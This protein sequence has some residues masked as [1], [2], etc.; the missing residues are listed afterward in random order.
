[1]SKKITTESFIAEAK[2]IYGDKYD[3]SKVNYINAK[4]K[5]CIICPKH[6]EFWI[7]PNQFISKHKGCPECSKEKRIKSQ[8][9]TKGQFIEKAKKIHGDKYDYSN[10]E[11]INS[12]TYVLIHCNT[13]GCDFKQKPSAHL[14]GQGCPNCAKNKKLDAKTFIEKA[15]Q[16][17]GDKYD[18]SKVNY[19]NKSTKVCIICPK[20]GEFLQCP[21]SHLKGCGCPKCANE[22]ATMTTEQFIEKAKKIHGDKYDYSKVK[23]TNSHSPVLIHCNKCGCEFEQLP[24][25]HLQGNGC[26]NCANNKKKSSDEFIEKAKSI[27]G[28]KYDYSK[29]NYINNSTKVCIICSKHGEFWQTPYHHLNKHGCPKCANEQ[30]HAKQKIG[31]DEFIKKAKEVHGDK[32][33]YSE[34]KYINSKTPVKIYCK[35]HQEFFYQAPYNHLKCQGCPKCANEQNCDKKRRELYT[36]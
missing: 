17:H 29:V 26:P 22:K 24:Y 8:T 12:R 15:K 25:T 3:Y 23:Y 31:K 19:I 10:T 36:C 32:Y 18:Y 33:D 13:C 35:K 11:Y 20:H 5:V 1:M 16:I 30:T 34:I 2:N 4:T 7:N 28:D 21:E 6:G 14:L 9:S 27:H